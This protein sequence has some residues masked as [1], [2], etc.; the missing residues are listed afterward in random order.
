M[1]AG[2]RD[3][4]TA[5]I[6]DIEILRAVAIL[7]T[8]LHHRI[9]ISPALGGG[10][11]GYVQFWGGVD[12]FFVVSG[13][14]IGRNLRSA[15]MA[16]A[17]G[18][19]IMRPIIAFWVRRIWRLWPTA[20]IWLL[21]YLI[22]P[23]LGGAELWGGFADNALSV[24]GAIAAVQN[25]HWFYCFAGITKC[26]NVGLSI[27]WSLSL[28]EQ[29]Y[30]ILPF[31]IYVLN[32]RN[33]ILF[34]IILIFVQIFLPRPTWSF[35]WVIRSDA[36]LLGVLIAIAYEQPMLRAALEPR[37]MARPVAAAATFLVALTVMAVIAGG[38]IVPFGTGLIALLSG[39]LV[40]CASYDRC[41]GV[42]A[43]WLRRILIIIGGRS[44]TLYVCHLP[45]FY[46]TRQAWAKAAPADWIG[47]QRLLPGL[48]LC[49]LVTTF[50]LAEIS[51]RI[52]E[53]PLRRYG[54]RVA[55]R[56]LAG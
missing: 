52:I 17:H 44:Y 16:M 3:E 56:Y 50:A 32:R 8:L 35:L 28:E 13:F 51:H 7:L 38:K 45:A 5:R 47:D 41:Y 10:L 24:V 48:V 30:L 31:L 27:Y 29:F 54:R 37:W 11:G 20:W 55:D 25:F 4:P 33:L 46:L 19:P 21:P 12:L 9:V 22:M 42:Q 14:V 40:W 53:R 1:S 34:C 6:G 39:A 18:T 15:R 26:G 36:L 43:S 2:S 49:A 23:G